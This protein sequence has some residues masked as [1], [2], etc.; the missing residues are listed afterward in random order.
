MSVELKVFGGALFVKDKALKEN[1]DLKPLA[2]FVNAAKK[3]VAEA[4]IAGKF[5]ENYPA[6]IDDYFKAKVWEHRDE[7]PRITAEPGMFCVEFFSTI[8]TWN[9]EAGEPVSLSEPEGE[10]QPTTLKLVSALDRTL[11]AAVMAR[12]GPVTEITD[13]QY[14]QAVELID[15]DNGSFQYQLAKA[16]TREPRVFVLSVDKFEELM[17]W[18]RKTMDSGT[19]AAEI[20]K[21]IS[22]WLDT[23]VSEHPDTTGDDSTLL[24]VKRFE[25]ALG[26]LASSMDFEILPVPHAIEQRAKKMEEDATDP[27]FTAWWKQLRRTPNFASHSRAGTVAMIKTA[28]EDLYLKP[29][30]LRAYIDNLAESCCGTPSQQLIDTACGRSSMPL[31]PITQGKSNNDETQSPVSVETEIP[32]VCPARAAELDKELNAAF[33]GSGNQG[34]P[35]IENLGGGVFSADALMGNAPSNEGEK[36]EVPP[37]PSDREI[38]IAH[39]LND[40]IYGRT[41]MMGDEEA[42][43]VVSC[44]GHLVQDVIPLLISDIATIEC[45]LSPDFSDEEIHDIATTMLDAWSDDINVRQKIA[46]DAIVEYRRPEPPKSAVLSSPS[47]TAKSNPATEP[48]R[49]KGEQHA[50]L[51]FRQQ[52]TIAAL[53]GLCANPAYSRDG[54]DLAHAAVEIVDE[55][56][57]YQESG[58][59]H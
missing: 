20:K 12:L 1:P 46:L 29:L 41:P 19:K 7:L 14:S 8:A 3:G 18:V 54:D 11:R 26:V 25:T 17:S 24:S 21:G 49:E 23:S 50:A 35:K 34:Q 27:R 42:A 22:G 5:A 32:A 28:P 40:L 4:I 36:Q 10:Q 45:C 47:V 2:I 16:F 48:A 30:D 37:A 59:E 15:K 9:S 39:A 43:G 38:E 55:V 33:A 53:Q 57:R 6:N 13:A 31:T 56:M 52:L 58:D 44:T 51:S